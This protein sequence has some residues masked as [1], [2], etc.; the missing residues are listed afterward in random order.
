MKEIKVK[1]FRCVEHKGGYRVYFTLGNE[2][3]FV[4][5]YNGWLSGD[6]VA[7]EKRL[8]N[9][10]CDYTEVIQKWEMS[11]TRTVYLSE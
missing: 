6:E 10:L 5:Y 2:E 3:R 11:D 9:S 4:G 8:T 1:N 7:D